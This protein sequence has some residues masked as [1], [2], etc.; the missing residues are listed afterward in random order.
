MPSGW[1]VDGTVVVVGA[2]VVVVVGATVV[3]VVVG[4]TV[5]DVVVGVGR[6]DR[7][8]AD[9]LTGAV[10]T[11]VTAMM[12]AMDKMV[13]LMPRP[14]VSRRTN[15]RCCHLI[16]VRTHALRTFKFRLKSSSL[17]RLGT[18]MEV[19]IWSRIVRSAVT[20]RTRWTPITA[21]NRAADHPRRRGADEPQDIRTRYR[22]ARI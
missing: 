12:T 1:T 15:R 20:V 7:F 10:M 8:G 6:R 21:G 4:A 13:R 2:T 17:V 3:V 22:G 19:S 18:N 5:V 16:R 14:P 11:T 9:P